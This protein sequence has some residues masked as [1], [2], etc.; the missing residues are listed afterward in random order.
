[1]NDEFRPD[2]RAHVTTD[3]DGVVRQVLHTD[4]RWLPN[5][6]TPLGAAMEYVRAHTGLLSIGE[7]AVDRLHE[8]VTYL[9]PRAESESLRLAEQK[10]QF[11]ST[12]VAF[13]QTYLNVPVWRTGVSVT[14]KEGPSRVVESTNTTLTD[15]RAELPSEDA[16]N[17]WREVIA[18][19]ERRPVAVGETEAP[20]S[21]GDRAVRQA[22]GLGR[23]RNGEAAAA[24][25]VREPNRLRLNRGRFF[26]YRYDPDARQPQAPDDKRADLEHD[27]VEPTFP[28]PPVPDSIRPGGDYL[29]VELLF[30]LPF[31]GIA[32][33]NWR[34]LVEVETNAVLYLRALIAGVNALVFT[35]DPLTSTGVLTNTANQPNAV[36]DPLRDDVTLQHLNGPVGGVQSLVGTRVQLIDDESP[37]IAP[38]T[39]PAGND[40]DYQTRTNE[41]AA[42][43]AYYHADELFST[44]E[45][46]GFTLS[47]YFDGTTFPVHVDHRAC[48]GA[49]LTMNAFCAGD[50]QGDGIGLVGYCLSDLTDTTNPL[51]RAVD[52]W[53]HWHEIGGHGILWDHVDSPN[54]GF[55]H[56]AGD[57][58]A[59]LQNDPE[60]Q[61]RQLGLI[62]RF[63]YA[64][65]RGLDRWM[66]RDVAAGWG[67]GG[68]ND[69]G[70]YESEQILAT[71]H[72]R[73]YR[74]IGGDSENLARRWFASRVMT[75]LILRSVGDLTPMTNPNSALTWCNKLMANDLL[76]WTSEGL[77][78]GAYNKVIRWAFEEQGLFQPAGAPTPV[79]S[80]GAPPAVDVY[81][82]DGRGGEYPYQPVHWNNG[83]IW[84]RNAPDG[85][86]THQ[87]AIQG[88]INFAYVRVKNR[89]T[90]AATNVLVKGYHSM[91][92]AGLTWPNDF[93][94]MYPAAG[95]TA[96]SIPAN[97]AGDVVLGPFEWVPNVNAYGHDCV[98]MIAS[99]AGDPSNIDNFLPG[100]T[101]E[102]WRLVPNDNNIGQRNVQL[103]PG[104][105]G[106]EGLLLGLNRHV[107]IAGNTFKRRARMQ[108]QVELPTLLQKNG[109]QVRFQGIQGD[110]FVLAPGEKR[111]I[112]IDLVPG[113]D[114]TADQVQ[115]LDNRDVVVTLLGN[116]MTIG[117]MTY[118]LD[119]AMKAPP[120]LGDGG[121]RCRDR[122]RDLLDCLDI[123]GDK[124]KSVH[125][126]KVSIDVCMDGDC[127]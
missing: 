63:R 49:G 1:M 106:K 29:V 124:V 112:V 127:C 26:I 119:P 44:I 74:S 36:L 30:T 83:S 41:F 23:G 86:T 53:V 56:S 2:L 126:T 97:S 105:G 125:V 80:A 61:L 122:A 92:G 75:Y 78:G 82:D 4:E 100:E 37:N 69:V 108:L 101:I 102:E 6:E 59:G 99:V 48:G 110:Q 90:T 113:L 54:F 45:S 32:G 65:F 107:F 11:D 38:P 40:F 57:G 50:A 43:N 66:N 121:Q 120:E 81:I 9:D 68:V 24:A 19:I 17:R 93:A 98:L 96:A 12:T 15:V 58:L 64:P 18:G 94:Q 91:P 103:V 117:G 10:H 55:A 16:I 89:G 33:L 3:D 123:P 115:S 52:K 84:N 31:A 20:A 70:G 28:L 13:A 42:A 14:V 8:P 67:W 118:R 109:W 71:S 5:K 7:S 21:P 51:G 27:D 111:E 22:L 104:G 34:A 35:Y 72:F 39:Q 62:D 79:T 73:I 116:G 95:H 60:S 46:L 114:F 77:S 85:L 88:V 76:D 87:S 25:V 47:T